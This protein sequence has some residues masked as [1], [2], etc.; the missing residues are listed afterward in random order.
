MHTKNLLY[1]KNKAGSV[2]NISHPIAM[3]MHCSVSHTY[4]VC[5]DTERPNDVLIQTTM[6]LG[7]PIL[8][9]H[10]A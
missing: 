8:S 5:G 6:L 1:L 2:G 3:S 10:K 7:V 9:T 4:C